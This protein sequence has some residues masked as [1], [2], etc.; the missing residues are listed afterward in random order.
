MGL[1]MEQLGIGASPDRLACERLVNGTVLVRDV[2]SGQGYSVQPLDGGEH[3]VPEPEEALELPGEMYGPGA[4]FDTEDVAPAPH[5][6]KVAA[7]SIAVAPDLDAALGLAVSAAVRVGKARGGSA[8]V[9]DGDSLR[10]RF[11]VGEHAERLRG[12]RIPVHAGVAGFSV[13]HGAA[14]VVNNAYSD[15]RFYR[16]VD[17]HTGHRTRALVC[18]P[19][20]LGARCLGCI[21]L[22][23]T[24]GAEGFSDDDLA[25]TVFL[26]TAVA[27]RAAT[28]GLTSPRST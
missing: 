7:E 1:G 24:L 5:V 27:N 25:E 17:R 8:L 21:E 16:N 22:V 15:P 3:E 10:F 2:R 9:R 19:V 26:A 20:G 28:L 23:D 6:I 12:M 11:V 14:L 18:A 13:A 4:D